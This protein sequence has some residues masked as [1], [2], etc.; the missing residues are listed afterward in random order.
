[1]N[2]QKLFSRMVRHLRKQGCHSFGA[3]GTCAYRGEDGRRCAIGILIPNTLYD[4]RIESRTVRSLL[5]G[6]WT[7]SWRENYKKLAKHLGIAN[8]SDIEFLVNAQSGLHDGVSVKRF[9]SELEAGARAMANKYNLKVP[10]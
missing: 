1:M 3:T 7:G 6:S 2:R 5:A 8:Q 4:K 10:A 9:S